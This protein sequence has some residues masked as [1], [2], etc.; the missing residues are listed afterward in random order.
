MNWKN[1][2]GALTKVVF[3]VGP[4]ASGKSGWAL[5]QAAKH[6]GVIINSDSVQFYKGLQVG[7]AAP[8]KDDLKK[9]PHYLYSYVEAPLEMT[10]GQYIRHFYQLIE[11]AKIKG[12]LF[13]VGGTGFYIQA[14]EKG[15]YD[16]E[17]I[18]PEIRLQIEDELKN[19]GAEKLYAELKAADPGSQIH[20]NDHFRLVR[21]I[22]ILRHNGKTPS[23]LKAESL[24][25][26]NKNSLP[27]PYIKVGFAYEKEKA[28][29]IVENRTQ[30]MI[31]GGLIEETNACLKQG[32]S[33]WAPL[34]SVGYKEAVD[35]L[36][37]NKSKD[38]LFENINKSTMQLIKKQKTWFKRDSTILWSDNSLESVSN[39][40]R[41]VGLFLAN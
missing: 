6:G 12:P 13:I 9:V 17:P 37:H 4:T 18:G 19:V 27:F 8:T 16:V 14:L 21:A 2:L 35:Y 29:P 1:Y 10:A 25:Q 39:L 32:F 23:V 26:K 22:E 11:S 24:S 15:M 33:D 40:D 7:S 5:A 30:L 41:R 34:A 28:L 31:D 20:L 36:I 38:W 3:V